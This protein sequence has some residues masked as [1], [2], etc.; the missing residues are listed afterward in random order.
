MGPIGPLP[1]SPPAPPSA[2]G[3][4]RGNR[5][6]GFYLGG[7]TAS[8]AGLGVADVLILWLVFSE[9]GSTLAVAAVGIVETIPPIAIGY[10]AGALADRHSRRGLL[11]VTTA[12]QSVS[13][14]LIPLS[15]RTVGF[16]LGIVL[17]LAF[18]LEMATVIAGLAANAILPGLVESD[19]LDGANALTQAFS[20]VAWA[21]GAAAAA[22]LLVVA[23]IS[24][25]F[26]V[27]FVVFA[28]GAGLVALIARPPA[29]AT[30]GK[31]GVPGVREQFL[32][33][34]R[35]L[36]GHGWLWRFTAVAVATGFFVTMFSP[37]LVV[38]TV[39]GLSLP[40]NDFGYLAGAYSAGFFA[41]SL[42]TARF[43]V[44]RYFGRWLG[45]ALLGSGGL[46]GLLV[47]VPNFAVD[48][49]TFAAMGGLMGLVITGSITLVQ[50][51]VPSELLG[52][53]LGLQE[54]LVWVVAPFGVA[55]GGVLIQALGVRDGFGV[56]ATG[57]AVVGLLTVLSP[58]LRAIGIPP[59]ASRGAG[60]APTGLLDR[61]DGVAEATREPAA[62]LDQV[63]P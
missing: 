9:T 24:V 27:N 33:G 35:F 39:E 15:L 61:D 42:L 17:T 13:L 54:T 26:G 25:S 58:R 46:L 21:A 11:I 56:A 20:S 59:A 3:P 38:F 45:V 5:N 49:V 62:L 32:E 52:R 6:F 19:G 40:A 47:V 50:K 41:G 8:W 4:V 22:G 36:R 23:D 37:Y 30:A 57:L 7:N 1:G 10:F 18:A 12:A 53:Y 63:R 28:L 48:L 31:D 55:T 14:G 2:P 51:V 29:R 60:P 34:V 44:V 16:Q 43:R